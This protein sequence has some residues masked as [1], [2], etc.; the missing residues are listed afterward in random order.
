M[1]LIDHGRAFMTDKKFTEK[2]IYDE[3]NKENKNFIM[4]Q[5]PRAFVEKLRALDAAS[6]K[7]AVGEYLT[8]KEI[9]GTLK[10]RDL[11]VAWID[12]HIK[13]KGEDY[14]LY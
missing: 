6:I 11:M 12:K 9:D 4:D 8:D 10:R 5:L 1:I 7:A 14:V 2:L 3:N 13:D